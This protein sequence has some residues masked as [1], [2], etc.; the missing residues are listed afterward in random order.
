MIGRP[1]TLRDRQRRTTAGVAVELGEHDAGEADAV[2]EGL[3]GGDR[4][5][6]DHRV[7]DEQDLVGRDRVAD[8]GGLLHQLGVDAEPAGGVDDDDVVLVGAGLGDAVAGDRDRVADGEPCSLPATLPGSGAKT[9][10]A[11][12]LAD[13]LQLGRRRSGR[14]RSAATSSGVWPSLLQP[15]GQLAG[16][17]GLAGA[18]QAGEHDHGR[19][20]L[21]EAAAGG[22]R[23]RGRVTSSSWT[24]LTTCC[25][26]FSACE[27]SAPSA[28]ARAPASVNCADDRQRDVGLEQREP[29]LARRWRRCPASDSRPLPR[30]FL[31]VAAR[32]SERV[33]NT[34]GRSSG[35]VRAAVGTAQRTRP[36][37]ARVRTSG[38][39]Q[40]SSSAA[41]APAPTR[42]AATAAT[43]SGL[44]QVE[45]V[46]GLARMRG[47]VRRADVD[48][49]PRPAPG[50]ARAAGPGRSG[51][52]TSSDGRLLRARR[53][54]STARGVA[55]DL[56]GDRARRR[57]LA[58]GAASRR[59][60]RSSDRQSPAASRC[61]AEQQGRRAA[62]ARRTARR[63]TRCRPAR[64]ST[65]RTRAER[66]VSPCVASSPAVS[67][68]RPSRSGATTVTACR[69]S[70]GSAL[71]LRPGAAPHRA[72]RQVEL[73]RRQRR[74]AAAPAAPVSG[75]PRPLGQVVDQPG[76]PRR[77][78]GRPGGQGVGLG[79]R[80]QQ[81][82]QV[83]AARRPPATRLDGRRV[84]GVAPGG[85]VDQQQVLAHQRLEDRRRRRRRSPSARARSPGER[86]AG[87]RVVGRAG[88]PCRCRAAGRA[89]QQ[90][91]GPA[92]RRAGTR[93]ASTTASTRCRSTVCRCTALRC[94]RR[95]DAGPSRAASRTMR[96]AWSQRL[97]DRRPAPA[98]APSSSS[99]ASRAAAGQGTGSGGQSAA[100][101]RDRRAATAAARAWAAVAAARSGSTGSSRR[102]DARRRAPPR[103]PARP[104]RGRAGAAAAGAAPRR[105]RRARHRLPRARRTVVSTA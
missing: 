39:S 85:Q 100:R 60:S 25:A 103:R 59:T 57:R 27:T 53:S 33:A 96:P 98:P 23:R 81:V 97:P 51:A 55:G 8:V 80:V 17:R 94:G 52:R 76:P 47:D 24:I 30:R 10:D 13:D 56:R 14:C 3:R 5:L 20:V 91:V 61:S 4:V 78:G 87:D 79:Q 82:Q 42:A 44:G 22:S 38:R 84:V 102:A 70:T 41:A 49:E 92:R 63:P 104:G 9:G 11:G 6:A 67:A 45:R 26:G 69:P 15:A 65:V 46:D 43:P 54:T 18:L 72:P 50:R 7:D 64:P 73:V 31:N 16:Q 105:S 66:T 29:D 58:A 32:R 83:A 71:D 101:L 74:R 1:V 37:A 34:A 62:A 90:Q 75:E 21:G 35:P 77:P 68:N 86:R 36:H 88:Q 89:T 93:S 40:A 2:Q 12:A 95:A 99:S 48:A 19:R 28:R